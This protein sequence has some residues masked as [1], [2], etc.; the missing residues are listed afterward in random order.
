[1]FV[2]RLYLPLLL[3][4]N[5]RVPLHPLQLHYLTRVVRLKQ[6]SA[7]FVFNEREGEYAATFDRK[8][9]EVVLL[10][11]LPTH[12][13]SPLILHLGQGMARPDRMDWIL[14]KATELGVHTITPLL[15]ANT[16]IRWEPK[17]W[18]SK[19]RHW[20]AIL[21]SAAEQSGRIMP[22]VLSSPKPLLEWMALPFEGLS[23]CFDLAQQTSFK[24]IPKASAYRLAIG[25]ESGWEEKERQRLHHS[26]Q[27]CSLGPRVLRTETAAITALALVQGQFGDLGHTTGG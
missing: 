15:C 21:I 4:E 23:L 27:V 9:E 2:P 25:P 7:L 17:H 20:N 12:R 16:S 8:K 24:Q 6:D 18:E 3:Q 26:F 5:Q 11:A 13:E 14:Q 10:K 22:P 19:A 1:M